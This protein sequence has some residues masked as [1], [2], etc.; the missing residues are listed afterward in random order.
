M[1]YYN[2]IDS[3]VASWL[4]QLIAMEQIPPGYIDERSITEIRP[5]DLIGFTQ[6]HFFCGIGGWPYALHLANIPETFPLWTGSP[7][8]QPFS[9][10]GRARGKD[11]SRHLAPAFLDLISECK[12]QFIFGEQVAAAI[13]KDHWA[14]SLLI[15]LEEEGYASGFAVLPACSV[16]APHQRNRM[17]FGA[18][19]MAQPM[20]S[21]WFGERPHG[22]AKSAGEETQSSSDQFAGHRDSVELVNA[23]RERLEREWR[24]RDPQGWQ[25][26]DV[27]QTGLLDRTGIKRLCNQDKSFWSDAD[28]ISCRDGKFRAVEPSTFPLAYGVPERMGRLR[29]YG[30]A[31]VPQVA[32]EFIDAFLRSIP[33]CDF[34]FLS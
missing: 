30:N 31:I 13:T 18:Y 26:S 32:A 11:D 15:E 6:C 24:N 19:D 16:G 1:N 27:R 23:Y 22:L 28:W 14:D 12:P 7:P 8:C 21:E 2:D 17:F 3:G 34:S 33:G 5:S 4:R 25:R 10:A 20:R 9:V 29:G